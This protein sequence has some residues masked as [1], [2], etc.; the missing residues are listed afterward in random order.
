MP[1]PLRAAPLVLFASLTLAACAA[2]PPPMAV[3]AAE[4]PPSLFGPG[5]G[6]SPVD[7]QMLA[8]AKAEDEIDKLFPNAGKPPSFTRRKA[9]DADA[10]KP[11]EPQGGEVKDAEKLATPDA[12]SIACRALDSMKS[13]ADHLCKLAGEGDGR[14]EDA[15]GRV[16]GASTRVRAVCPECASLGK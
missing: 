8:I 1:S 5:K 12:C 13:S 15:R 3:S 16:R 14:C 6:T 11:K 9:A 10:A 2:A 4:A 7:Q